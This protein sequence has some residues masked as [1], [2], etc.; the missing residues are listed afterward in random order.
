MVPETLTPHPIWGRLQSVEQPHRTEREKMAR[1]PRFFV[2]IV[3]RNGSTIEPNVEFKTLA[4][5]NRF[6]L[7]L[8]V[9]HV[10]KYVGHIVYEV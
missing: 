8:L 1:N 9:K 6:A 2:R 5:A 7:D 4:A 10:D 3:R